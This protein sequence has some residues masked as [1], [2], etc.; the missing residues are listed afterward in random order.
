MNIDFTGVGAVV[1]T[2]E[3][4]DNVTE[5]GQ[6]VA[7]SGSGRVGACE[8]GNH[9]MGMVK[10][11]A[12]GYA[13]VQVRGYINAKNYGSITAGYKCLTALDEYT[14]KEDPNGAQR[15]VIYATDDY[16]GVLL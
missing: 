9:P 5:A 16:V 10:S 12:N 4:E 11:V 2:F 8:N 15:L 1:A 3:C 14:L 7:L 13:A 6:L